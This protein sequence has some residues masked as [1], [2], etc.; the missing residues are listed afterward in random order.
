MDSRRTSTAP[1]GFWWTVA[2]T[3][4]AGPI[5][6]IGFGFGLARLAEAT[7]GG[8]ASLAGA[9]IGLWLGA[10]F[11]ALVV[12][13]LCLF[14]LARSLPLRRGIAVLLMLATVIIEAV[15]ILVGL[16]IMSGADSPEFGMAAIAIIAVGV[17]GAGAYLSLSIA[18]RS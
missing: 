16:R 15:V 18:R 14:T 1:P 11:L 5:G 7:T 17:L 13:S 10:P 8:M 6:S 3:T 4:I 2:L 9:V 12:F